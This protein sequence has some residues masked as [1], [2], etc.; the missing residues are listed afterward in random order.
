MANIRDASISHH[1]APRVYSCLQQEL[2]KLAND[3]LIFN[4]SRRRACFVLEQKG[5]LQGFRMLHK[6]QGS[7][8][9]GY[10]V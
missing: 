6:L 9:L 1:I 7:R 5:G 2:A 8:A 3:H 4:K 10:V